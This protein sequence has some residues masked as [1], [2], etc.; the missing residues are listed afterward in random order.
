M[1]ISWRKLHTY[2]RS[3]MGSVHAMFAKK[4]FMNASKKSVKFAKVFQKFPAIR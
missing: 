2:Y 1:K 3:N 4:T